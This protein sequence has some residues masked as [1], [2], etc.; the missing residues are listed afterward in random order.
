M[1][2]TVDLIAELICVAGFAMCLI[3]APAFLMRLTKGKSD[4]RI[5]P[6]DWDEDPGADGGAAGHEAVE[7]H[8]DRPTLTGGGLDEP[9]PAGRHAA[10][11]TDV[12]TPRH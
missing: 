12:D 7:Q 6:S 3:V 9:V 11:E 5:L 8:G 2:D 1:T 4:D 10:D